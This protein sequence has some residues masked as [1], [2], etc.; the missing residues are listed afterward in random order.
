MGSVGA[1]RNTVIPD[2]G[3]QINSFENELQ[4]RNYGTSKGYVPEK[5]QKEYKALKRE[6]SRYLDTWGDRDNNLVVFSGGFAVGDENYLH[7]SA[8][9]NQYQRLVRSDIQAIKMD[10]SL[11]VITP[12]R[13]QKELRV[14][15]SID[16]TIKERR[17][18]LNRY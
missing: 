12:E 4:N 17:E 14:V 16:A 2:I 18:L 7:T 8:K 3:T 9:L 11:G 10:L 15:R 6:I 13:A 1:N 5:Q